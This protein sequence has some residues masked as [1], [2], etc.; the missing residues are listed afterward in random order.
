MEILNL[1]QFDGL[2]L[3]LPLSRNKTE[4]ET[5]LE[6][7]LNDI[8]PMG[9]GGK[10]AKTNVQYSHLFTKLVTKL[11]EE[12][13]RNKF[14]LTMTVLPNVNVSDYY[15]VAEIHKYFKFIN[16]FAF[17]FNTPERDP[18]RADYSAPLYFNPEEKRLPYANA[19]FQ[20]KYWL[21]QGCPSK[22]LNLGIATYGRAWKLTTS[23][24]LSGKPIVENTDGPGGFGNNS[25]LS[26]PSICQQLSRN[27]RNG[28]P[29]T[30]RTNDRNKP[31]R[32]GR[33]KYFQKRK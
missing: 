22:K 27:C 9:K 19:D 20:V 13:A 1:Y 2:D 30:K 11:K 4:E 16:L 7:F 14:D 32:R 21:Q 8:I 28:S 25:L 31:W 10:E 15:D 17:D 33:A 3:A 5:N 24:G 6:A 29:L 23:S 18:S 12:C 26:W